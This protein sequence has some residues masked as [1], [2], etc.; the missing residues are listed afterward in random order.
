M[1]LIHLEVSRVRNL[2]A[3]T[4]TP[5]DQINLIYGQNASGK[6]SLLE[7]ITCSPWPV[8]FAAT[9]FNT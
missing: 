4:M 2:D 8:P 1:S 9:R 6:T 7:A 3:V 5:C